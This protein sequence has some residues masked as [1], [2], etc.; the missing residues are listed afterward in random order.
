M[1]RHNHF[2]TVNKAKISTFFTVFYFSANVTVYVHTRFKKKKKNCNLK[3]NHI[4]FKY[5]LLHL[6]TVILDSNLTNFFF[7]YQTCID[8]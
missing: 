1:L 3:A 7:L 8:V 4:S 5:V 6:N 2:K